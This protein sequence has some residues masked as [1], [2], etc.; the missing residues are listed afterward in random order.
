VATQI[1]WNFERL[2]AAMGHSDYGVLQRYVR[3][4]TDRAQVKVGEVDGCRGE[5][6][7][8]LSNRKRS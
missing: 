5:P 1:G 2:R 7:A 3:L 6:R 4:A 8:L